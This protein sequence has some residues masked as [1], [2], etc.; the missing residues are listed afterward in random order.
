M[1]IP[2]HVPVEE[3]LEAAADEVKHAIRRVLDENIPDVHFHLTAKGME[4]SPQS[5]DYAPVIETWDDLQE[6]KS[7]ANRGR[8]RAAHVSPDTTPS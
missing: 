7:R 1:K 4:L 6:W 3:L 8:R 5:T 2:I